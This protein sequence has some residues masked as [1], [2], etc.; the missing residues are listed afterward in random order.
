M[1]QGGFIEEK[2]QEYRNY[3]VRKQTALELCNERK[4]LW[5]WQLLKQGF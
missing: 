4:L 1:G 2:R 3:E 5:A